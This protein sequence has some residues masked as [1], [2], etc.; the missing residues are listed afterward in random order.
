M[1]GRLYTTAPIRAGER[2][3]IRQDNGH[4]NV[5]RMTENGFYMESADCDNQD[6][7]HMGTVTRE[8]WKQRILGT[9]VICLPNRVDVQLLAEEDAG[10][11]DV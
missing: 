10:V 2:I 7:V 1:D 8:N 9:H 3:E 5:V 11:P 4:V 6:C